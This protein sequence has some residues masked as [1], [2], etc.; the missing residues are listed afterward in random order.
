MFEKTNILVAFYIILIFWYSY[1]CYLAQKTIYLSIFASF[2]FD[3]I[4]FIFSKLL[5]YNLP[6]CLY[7]EG[8]S[9]KSFFSIIYFLYIL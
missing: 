1:R 5:E 9:S 3:V 8:K 4:L 2:I 6:R 7:D